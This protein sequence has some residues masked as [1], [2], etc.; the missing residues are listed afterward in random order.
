MKAMPFTDDSGWLIFCPACQV[1]HKFSKGTWTFNGDCARPTFRASMLVR[2]HLGKDRYGVCHSFVTDG[3]I[4]FLGDST[5]DLRG[6]TVELPDLE[7]LDGK[8][9]AHC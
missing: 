5:H 8:S 2:G 7:A 6:Q 9:E 4:E 3:M 1:G